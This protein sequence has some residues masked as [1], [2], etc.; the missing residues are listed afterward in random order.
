M[1]KRFLA[2]PTALAVLATAAMPALAQQALPKSPVST[3][4]LPPGLYVQ[5]ID[6]LIN[7]TNKGGSQTFAPGQFGFTPTPVQ[8]PVVVPKNPGLQFTLPPA[9]SVPPTVTGSSSGAKSNAVDCEVR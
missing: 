6:G 1:K 5:V 7:V 4:P 3:P 2:L 8:A 9:F